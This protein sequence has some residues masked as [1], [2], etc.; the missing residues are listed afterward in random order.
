M[1]YVPSSY[2]RALF[3]LWSY[4]TLGLAL[5][6]PASLTAVLA[7]RANGIGQATAAIFTACFL[8]LLADF[9][10]N[11][12]MPER[13]HFRFAADYRWLF[14]SAMAIIYWMYGTLALLP[15]VAP[16]GSWVLVSSYFG[17]GGWGMALAFHTKVRAYKKEV[18]VHESQ[19]SQLA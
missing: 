10:V 15:G 18:A 8:V 7:E 19:H 9:L 1:T 12:V 14:V 16:D 2:P 6:S 13:F 5:K 4:C 17:V 3:L 11:D